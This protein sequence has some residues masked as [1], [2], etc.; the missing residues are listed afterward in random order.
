VNPFGALFG[1][2]LSASGGSAGASS[3]GPADS[4]SGGFFNNAAFSVGGSGQLT[5]T[6]SP[7]NTNTPT[8]TL[9]GGGQG[10]PLYPTSAPAVSGMDSSVLLGFAAVA[11][12]LVM[13]RR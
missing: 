10:E 7:T 12:A 3:G 8:N 9:T 13:L 4:G 2:G 1:G 6:E 5:Q 11:L